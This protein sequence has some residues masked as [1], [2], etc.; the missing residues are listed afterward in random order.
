[1]KKKSNDF[2][3]S[4]HIYKLQSKHTKL[5]NLLL[6]LT[7]PNKKFPNPLYK[8]GYEPKKGYCIDVELQLDEKRMANPDIILI[9]EK[10]GHILFF[11][12]K[13]NTVKEEQA[14]RYQFLIS[15]LNDIINLNIREFPLKEK[16]GEFVGDVSYI[17]FDDLTNNPIL[18]KFNEFQILKV[19][20]KEQNGKIEKIKRI[21]LKRGKYKVNELNDI[22]PIEIDDK[23]KPSFIMYPIDIKNGHEYI[24]LEMYILNALITLATAGHEIPEEGMIFSEDIILKK[25]NYKINADIADIEEIKNFFEEH[26]DKIK[27]VESSDSIEILEDIVICKKGEPLEKWHIK[28]IDVFNVC[29][30]MNKLEKRGFTPG[31]LLDIFRHRFGL[32]SLNYMYRKDKNILLKKIEEILK[33]IISTDKFEKL[34]EYEKRKKKSIWKIR[35]MKNSRQIEAFRYKCFEIIQTRIEKAYTKQMTLDKFLNK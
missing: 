9:N 14:N 19:D 6:N 32:I 8:L 3:G 7:W 1:M 2:I 22:F 11:E 16:P 24:I 27:N 21:V 20:A 4:E 34:L 13:S 10:K 25:G 29:I 26:R 30:D 33:S 18:K 17:S 35:V 23:H 12:C 5:V 31:K 28:V 15:N